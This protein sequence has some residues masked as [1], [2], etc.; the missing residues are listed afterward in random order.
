MQ[1]GIHRRRG[2]IHTDTTRDNGDFDPLSVLDR[3]EGFM[4]RIVKPWINGAAVPLQPFSARPRQEMNNSDLDKQGQHPRFE[5]KTSG[6]LRA[7]RN[8]G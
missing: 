6:Y 7:V 4:N 8:T 3:R 1:A 5:G 2:I